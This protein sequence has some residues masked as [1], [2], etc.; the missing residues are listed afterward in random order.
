MKKN[1]LILVAV[2]TLL[3]CSRYATNGESV[4]LKSHNG[5]KL[6]VPPPLTRSNLS[7]FYVLPPQNQDA[8]VTI[9]RPS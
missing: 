8:R 5:V 6:E 3:G 1:G 4:Y 9:E 2:M 7:D